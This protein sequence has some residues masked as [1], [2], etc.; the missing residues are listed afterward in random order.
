MGRSTRWRLLGVALGI[1]AT[2]AWA[3]FP[4][5]SPAQAAEC[6]CPNG[7]SS[8]GGQ[9]TNSTSA[10][11]VFFACPTTTTTTNST[12]VPSSSQSTTTSTNSSGPS[13]PTV[14]NKILVDNGLPDIQI[15]PYLLG[16]GSGDSDPFIDTTQVRD[17]GNQ[18]S[19]AS[20]TIAGQTAGGR[21]NDVG[22]GA[23]AQLNFSKQI[24]LAATQA[25][26]VGGMFRYDSLRA[27]YDTSTSLLSGGII[28]PT[29]RHSNVYTFAGVLRYYTG[30]AYLTG[31]L[32]GSWGRGDWSDNVAGTTASF[33]THGFAAAASV[34]N[35]FTL[36]DSRVTT[37]TTAAIPT[38]APPAPPKQTGGYALQ[39]DLSA[40]VAYSNNQVDGYN[41]S[42][43]FT[44]GGEQYRY[45]LAGGQAKLIMTVPTD[46]LT[47]KPWASVNVDQ[48]FGFSHTLDIPV[49]TAQAA[50]TIYFG[51]AQTFWGTRA[52]I[53]AQHSSGLRVGLSGVFQQSSQ[54]QILGGQ[55]YVRY[56]LPD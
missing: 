39:L 30:S 48:Q 15:I 27:N 44:Y 43:G 47:W 22:G 31:G 51:S 2:G 37:R 52:G 6:T 50:D 1:A 25:I 8:T 3:L 4:G 7:L 36:F 20:G 11:F 40:R 29:S 56:R 26:V 49:Q 10:P 19:S 9:C 33:N 23:D 5:S 24:N 18:I 16:G 41:D 55:V 38:K 28:D 35:V 54:Y 17:R 45:W 53:E 12:P 46:Y 14:N 13:K 42:T 34:G 21:T 32:G